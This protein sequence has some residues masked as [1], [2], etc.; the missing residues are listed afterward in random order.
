[1]SHSDI[2]FEPV[3]LVMIRR[4]LLPISSALI[5]PSW[6]IA[7]SSSDASITD[8]DE[9][10][11]LLFREAILTGS[12]D[13]YCAI[14]RLPEA[15]SE[16][17][18]QRTE[19]SLA[20]YLRRMATRPTPYGLLAGIAIGH[21]AHDMSLRFGPL[22]AV[23]TNAQPDIE[24]LHAVVR[25]L[26]QHPAVLRHVRLH[27]NVATF[28]AGGRLH[29]PHADTYGLPS[30]G[31]TSS[32]RATA[33]VLDIL[34]YARDGATFAE[35]ESFI[36]STR[37]HVSASQIEQSLMTFIQQGLLRSD[38]RP[39]LTERYPITY[40][41]TRLAAIPEVQEQAQQLRLV[42]DL[43]TAY[44]RREPDMTIETLLALRRAMEAVVDRPN[45]S[46]VTIDTVVPCEAASVSVE[47]ANEI[48]RAAAVLVRLSTSIPATRTLTEY[49]REFLK[50][51]GEG[52]EVPLL[53]LL[54][55]E[56][57]LGPP[58]TYQ[59]PPRVL[60]PM[61]PTPVPNRMRN[62]V[63]LEIASSA[64][65]RR[66]QEIYL[67]EPL[68]RRLQT[69]D[70]WQAFAPPSIELYAVIAA[71]SQDAINSGEYQV[72]LGPMAGDMPAG[73]A[74]GR[75]WTA[76]G[77]E[78]LP[79]LRGLAA[80]DA[81][82]LPGRIVAELEYLPEDDR[83]ANVARHPDVRSFKI[84]STSAGATDHGSTVMLDD[85]VVGVQHDRF[86]VRSRCLGKEV[87]ARTSHMLN[88][89]LAPNECR[90]LLEVADAGTTYVHPFDWG[91]AIDLPFLPRLRVGKTIIQL[92]E[93][94]LPLELLGEPQLPFDARSE[95]WHDAIQAWRSQWDVPRF[96]Y[97]ADNDARLLLDLDDP[98]CVTELGTAAR[99]LRV[100]RGLV[101]LQEMLPGF[102]QVWAEGPE[103]RYLVE[104]VVPLRQAHLTPIE[105]LEM[106]AQ[107]VSRGDRLRPVG[108]EWL[109]MK[110]Y[111][112]RSH[113]DDLI[114]GPITA[115]V[116]QLA[117]AALVTG[118]FFVRYADPDHHVRVRLRGEPTA[119]LTHALPIITAWG[120]A[121]I[122]QG[123]VTRVT[124]DTYDREV[125]RYGG[126]EGITL[127]EDLFAGDSSAV[128]AI[129]GLRLAKR[130]V[131][132]PLDV[133]L[134]T[135]DDLVASLGL[136]VADRLELYR[137]IRTGSQPAF[138]Q[139]ISQL[140]RTFHDY[141]KTAQRLI[142]DRPWLSAQPG[143]MELLS[144]LE[145]RACILGPLGAQLAQA[146]ATGL[147][148]TSIS[149]FIASC[150]HM[151]CNRLLGI[152]RAAE[153]DV[154][155]NLER[156]IDSLLRSPYPPAGVLQPR[157]AVPE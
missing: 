121:L 83:A 65:R 3:G 72:V 82:W 15:T 92:A 142:A 112:G 8:P 129:T 137:T 24:W 63:L 96:V 6:Y 12:Y 45:L 104:F 29:I 42:G 103:G 59:N 100:S 126:P 67:D 61:G 128:A 43:L 134:I 25:Q 154:L 36:A 131:L 60:D 13:L 76:L 89:L 130:L 113:Q 136:P 127:A 133:A 18:Q 73:R 28:V 101:V 156:T 34:A 147:L 124:F 132:E 50:R 40:V 55:E 78:L 5:S 95:T 17:Q 145:A 93:W 119:L 122:E 120:N 74:F 91:A 39:P 144:C 110:L 106:P 31:E 118:W 32:M 53:E 26:E 149:S 54:D 37:P 77:D 138:T 62:Q 105:P 140:R 9:V 16:K 99:R 157:D 86:Y 79:Q 20:R 11:R 47:V 30:T 49:R 51:Y 21:V 38:L 139:R 1:M 44:D 10:Q 116:S 57:G 33:L 66:Q 84:V 80:T 150:T 146:S 148:Q 64:I 56:T 152:N 102:D 46:T 4:P 27:S 48:A 87:V 155:Y 2:L 7:D 41:L 23:R 22:T 107:L 114:A 14:A 143:G 97:L 19:A 90:F 151:H 68:L 75:F 94:H 117:V 109:Y 153:F 88:Y 98:G 123:L 111:C 85:L 58:P 108:T 81:Q 69:S 52:Q 71:P 125:E 35:L 141:R 135:V 70:D 115:L